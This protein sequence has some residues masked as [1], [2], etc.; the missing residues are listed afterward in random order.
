MAAHFL[1]KPKAIPLTLEF[2]AS[3]N[4]E[5]SRLLLAKIRWGSVDKQVCPDCAVVDRHHNIHTRKQWRCKHCYHTFSVTS[6]TPFADHKISYRKLLIAIFSFIIGHKGLAALHLRRIIGGQYRTSFTLL[7][8]IR[9]TIMMNMPIAQLSGVVEIDGGH[10]SGKKRKGRTLTKPEVL[11][12][13]KTQV[14]TKYSVQQRDKIKSYEFPHHPN[15]RIVIVLRETSSQKSENINPHTGKEK[16]VGATRTIVAVCRSENKTDI[17][18]LVHKYVAKNSI[19]RS[20]ELSA[21]GNL[22]FQGYGHETVNHSKEF[23]TDTG[24]NQNQAEA[25]FSRMRRSFFGIY[26]RITPR[27]MLDYSSEIAWREDVRRND[28]NAQL[29]M[30]VRY[31]FC[32]GVSPDWSNYCRGNKR[33]VELLFQGSL[34]VV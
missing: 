18:A 1:L 14:P 32:S 33:K 5:Q 10:F 9:E 15:R 19:I 11:P 28:T 26:H 16:G 31:I 27:Y 20:D 30:L 7:H 6:G 13:D 12:K 3:L 17:E 4:E 25:F 24:V 29:Q 22:K 8:K 2:I 34:S 23:S 21:Y